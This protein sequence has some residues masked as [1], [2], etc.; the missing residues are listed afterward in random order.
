MIE[1]YTKNEVTIMREKDYTYNQNTPMPDER[2]DEY[3]H[4]LRESRRD[5]NG[6]VGRGVGRDQYDYD[7]QGYF[8]NGGTFNGDEHSTDLFKKGNHPTVSDQSMYQGITRPEGIVDALMKL[9]PTR[10]TYP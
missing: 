7:I 6:V 4:W 8:Q 2:L 1:L 9:A 5:E 3:N 10:R